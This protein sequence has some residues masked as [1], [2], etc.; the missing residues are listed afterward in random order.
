MIRKW[1][2]IFFKSKACERIY[3]IGFTLIVRHCNVFI[4]V[5][6]FVDKSCC[7]RRRHSRHWLKLVQISSENDKRKST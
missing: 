5:V 3:L 2:K 1:I 6:K 7:I 4:S